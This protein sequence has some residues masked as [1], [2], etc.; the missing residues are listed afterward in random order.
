[1][2]IVDSKDSSPTV[3]EIIEEENCQKNNRREK[4]SMSW[5]EHLPFDVVDMH[6]DLR[7]KVDDVFTKIEKIEML[8][9]L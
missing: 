9:K 6:L 1:M 8:Q 5:T 4:L 2:D 3:K 7:F